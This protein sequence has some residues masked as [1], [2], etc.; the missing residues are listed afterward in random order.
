[1]RVLFELAKESA[2]LHLHIEALEGGVDGFVGLDNY[3]NQLIS[4]PRLVLESYYG[5]IP[6]GHEFR[7]AS[8]CQSRQTATRSIT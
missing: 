2:L 5:P 4:D 7:R 6:S 3:V 8:F 1:M